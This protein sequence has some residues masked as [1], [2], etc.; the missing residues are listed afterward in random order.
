M[1]L[2]SPARWVAVAVLA[3]VLSSHSTAGAAPKAGTWPRDSLFRLEWNVALRAMLAWFTPHT[4]VLRPGPEHAGITKG[5][6]IPTP[7]PPSNPTPD[8]L[9]E[10]PAWDP[11]G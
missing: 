10:G 8:H 7:T 9:D 11:F 2:K 6:S 4:E 3:V 1:R 5:T